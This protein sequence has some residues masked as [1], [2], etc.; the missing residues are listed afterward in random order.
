MNAEY[1]DLKMVRDKNS[2]TESRCF[3]ICVICGICV[4]TFSVFSALS[5][6]GLLN[7]GASRITQVNC[8][9]Y[10]KFVCF[11]FL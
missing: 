6:Y 9:F 3:S 7:A 2:N 1:A 4:Q 5:G 10:P 8:P 11:H